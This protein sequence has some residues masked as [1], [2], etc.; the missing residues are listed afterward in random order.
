MRKRLEA[1]PT[2][3]GFL[4]Q[5]KIKDFCIRQEMSHSV[6]GFQQP[7]KKRVIKKPV[8]VFFANIKT[9]ENIFFFK[10]SVFLCIM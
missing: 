3:R 1:P 10:I 6:P 5:T 8:Q 9:N 4:Q 7:T 2:Q